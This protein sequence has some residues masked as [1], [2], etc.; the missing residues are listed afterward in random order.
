MFVSKKENVVYK[1]VE[2]EKCSGNVHGLGVTR[3]SWLRIIEVGG[4]WMLAQSVG[5]GFM[6]YYEGGV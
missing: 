4:G 6:I 1:M 3:V 5:W 2:A